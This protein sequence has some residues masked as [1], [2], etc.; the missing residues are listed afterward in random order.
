VY[1]HQL[2]S[3]IVNS[4]HSIMCAAAVFGVVDCVRDSRV[5]QP[6][7]QQ[8]IGDQI[9]AAFVF[10]RA[11]FI[12]VRRLT[13]FQWKLRSPQKSPDDCIALTLNHTAPFAVKRAGICLADITKKRVRPLF[14]R[15]PRREYTHYI[16]ERTE[17]PP[18]MGGQ[19]RQREKLDQ[20]WNK[21]WNHSIH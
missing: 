4:N 20:L 15:N 11:D 7:K 1:F 6:T 21:R 19:E 10:A 16:G 12:G 17:W 14:P 3:R 2:A 18:M 5:P 8:R 9:K 13:A